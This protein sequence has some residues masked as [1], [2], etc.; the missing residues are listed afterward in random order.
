MDQNEDDARDRALML[1]GRLGALNDIVARMNEIVE[2]NAEEASTSEL[3]SIRNWQ[4]LLH[5]LQ[6]AGDEIRG[7]E[8]LLKEEFAG[9]NGA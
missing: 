3:T 2:A 9:R 1:V 5:W 6:T 7:E 8:T 4:A